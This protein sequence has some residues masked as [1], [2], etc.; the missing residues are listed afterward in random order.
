VLVVGD[1]TLDEF[2][3]GAVERISREA[4]VVILRHETTRQVPG[5][6]ANA[7]ANLATLGVQ[8]VAI[9]VIGDD[10]Q[11]EVLRS[12]LATQGVDTKSLVIDPSRPTV[13]KTRIAAHARQSVTQQVVRID[14]KSDAPLD[15]AVEAHLVAAIETWLPQVAIIICSDYAEGVF[16]PAVIQACLKHPVVIVDTHFDLYRFAGAS[17]F[18]PN[19]PE[20]E[21]AAGF[22]IVDEESLHQAG[23]TLL[24]QTQAE[25]ILITRGEL[26]MTLFLATGETY[27]VPAFNRTQVFDVT[28]AGDTVVA[29]WTAARLHGADP[30]EAIVLGNLAA[31]IVV[32]RFG[33]STTNPAELLE[34]LEQ[35]P[36]IS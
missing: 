14:R 30:Y 27:S 13:T 22:R 10:L 24:A 5:G 25:S 36:W 29:G 21:L 4:P 8:T 18:T 32:R 12:C 15:P 19:V 9:G 35:V 2:M 1:F 26:G 16:T 6:A 17:L 31:S 34:Y 3:T 33:T 11:G 20:A 23:A 28:G 7:L